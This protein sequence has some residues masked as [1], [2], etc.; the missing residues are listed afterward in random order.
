MA[1]GSNGGKDG[2]YREARQRSAFL[3]MVLVMVIVLGDV[4]GF[5][6]YRPD[7]LVVS[8]LLIAAGGMLAVDIPGLRR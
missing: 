4:L 1:Q 6:P 5:S 2:Q 7:P 8:S 3:L